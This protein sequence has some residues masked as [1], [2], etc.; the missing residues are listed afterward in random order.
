MTAAACDP[1]RSIRRVTW[2]GMIVN[3]FLA[4]LKFVAGVFGKSSVLIADAVHSLSDLT[5]DAAV[6]IGSRYWDRPADSDHPN[7]HAKIESLVTLFIG[8]ALAWVA[9]KLM[10]DAAVSLYQLTEGSAIPKP[11]ILA[12]AAALLSIAVKE[13]LYRVTLKAARRADSSAA[14]ANAYHHRSDALSSIPAAVSVG[15][16][17]LFGA[18]WTFLDPVATIVVSCMIFFSA[19]QI[20]RSPLGTLIDRGETEEAITQI[21]DTAN[22]FPD[23]RSVHKIRTR[24]LGG[25][26]FAAD[27]HLQVDP[28]MTV[29]DAHTLSHQFSGEVK[30]RNPN[31]ADVVV[32]IEP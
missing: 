17:L 13:Y 24:P 11:G 6:L 29:R 15:V 2:L 3:L 26:R 16:C 14:A 28:A 19:C 1:I 12:L 27:L 5:T 7:G 10:C 32:H 20:L 31:I 30:R 9:V 4:A 8:L 25:N 23:I 21:L 18:R 22:T